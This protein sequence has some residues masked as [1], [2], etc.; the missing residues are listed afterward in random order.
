MSSGSGVTRMSTQKYPEGYRNR[1]I[2]LLLRVCAREPALENHA[3]F[4][5]RSAVRFVEHHEAGGA[6]LGRHR[7]MDT[8]QP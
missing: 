4:L 5:P 7:G 6:R 1:A 2:K 3:L 8:S